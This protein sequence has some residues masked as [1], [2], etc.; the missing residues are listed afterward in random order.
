MSESMNTTLNPKPEN[1]DEDRGIFKGF[2]LI[3][4][5]MVI[6][7]LSIMTAIAFISMIHYRLT[8]NANASVR[9][10]GGHLRLARANAIRE[11]GSY[12]FQ[13]ITSGNDNTFVY[14]KSTS[15][16]AGAACSYSGTPKSET[17]ADGIVFGGH[18]NTAPVPGHPGPSECA[19]C[20]GKLSASNTGLLLRRDGSI[21]EDGVAYI[22]PKNDLEGGT[23]T[24]YD[25]MRAADW[26]AASGRIRV[27]KFKAAD[28]TR[29]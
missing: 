24:R 27:W 25:R 20:F 6:A 8:I 7:I 10:I 3:E 15:E 11:G 1:E 4:L 26:S 9:E 16:T 12:C 21:S 19:V 18:N 23:G 22:I 17:M 28:A 2:S 13:F 29:S 14:G 5:L